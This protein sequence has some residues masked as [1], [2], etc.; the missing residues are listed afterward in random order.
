MKAGNWRSWMPK[1][2]LGRDV[3]GATLGIIGLGRI[4]QAVARRAQGFNMR[5]IYHGGSD[6]E[7]AAKLGAEKVSL[8]ELLQQS[9]FISLHLPLNSQTRHIIDG[10]ALKKMKPTAI[11]VNTARGG[12]ID[13]VALYDAL[14]NGKIAAAGLDVTDPEP[15]TMDDPLLTLDNCLI[16]PHLGSSSIDT[17]NRMAMIAAQNILA[18]LNG[19]R[20][21]HCVNPEVYD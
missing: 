4:G 10:E 14:K 9:D 5:I 3:F 11:L 8:D 18:G 12:H 7:A 20:L 19:D 15:I 21:P 2:L 6:D 1:L 16:I 17:R 13:P